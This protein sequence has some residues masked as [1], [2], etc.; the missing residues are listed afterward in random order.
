MFKSLNI[1]TRLIATLSLLAAVILGLVG[2]ALWQM[3]TMRA[4]TQEIT[5]NWLP[6][7][8]LINTMNTATSDF[9][10]AELS[11]VLSPAEAD[12]ARFEKQLSTVAADFDK[13]RDAYVALISSDRERQLYERFAAEWKRYLDIHRQVL[14]ASRG[15]DAERARTLLDKEGAPVF[16]RGSEL[17]DELIK[18]NHDGGMAESDNAAKAYVSARNAMLAG[19]LA[20]LL[21]AGV[22]GFW[23]VR[24]IAG[25]LARAVDSADR[26][27]EGDFTHVI[28]ADGDDEAA[29]VLKSLDRAQQA[30]SDVVAR[31]RSNAES[32]AT[33][34]AEIAQG[35]HDLSQR[36]EEQ[37]SALEQTAATMEEL[38]ATV[39]N[40]ADSAKQA[41]QLAVGASSIAARGGEVV[42]RVVETMQGISASSRKIGDIIGVIDGIAFQTNILAL[43]AAVEAA[44]AGEQGRGFAVVAGEVRTLAQRS[45]EAA[46]EIKSL[47]GHS[48]DQ[49]EQGAGL[50]DEAGKTMGEI[51]EAIQ[52][53]SDI[54]GEIT[55][56]SVEQSSGI[57][58][59]GD[60]ISQMDQ[61]TQQNAALVEQ[62]AAAAESL[63]AQ[64]KQLVE[65]VAVF[66][67]AGQAR[68]AVP[69]PSVPAPVRSTA[70][71]T[72]AAPR[73]SSPRRPAA[74]PVVAPAPKS[75][76]A[77]AA[78]A[79]V[80]HDDDWTSF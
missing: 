33:A 78:P 21:I 6:S 1:T 66:K 22:A 18:L 53:V 44:R 68:A 4:S 41:S 52:R 72:R 74:V 40:N 47:I 20:G 42:G 45:A 13:T 35:N 73:P 76:A 75:Q 29:R 46:K 36:T 57:S 9:R 51:V 70:P 49:V 67:L 24:S 12:K 56:A 58:Q 8:E 80:A 60:A 79:K 34:S 64:A 31:V 59:V 54:V 48:V 71:V 61:V 15:N 23:L 50:V 17:L 32:V 5:V 28:H 16:D 63:K 65:V 10:V 30:L 55:S 27:A 37:A 38:N 3:G 26:V 43:N 62:S 69:R 2:L 11:H 39:R 19:A 77:P 25:P 7:V 14:A